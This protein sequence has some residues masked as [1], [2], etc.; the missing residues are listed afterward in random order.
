[1]KASRIVFYLNGIVIKPMTKGTTPRITRVTILVSSKSIVIQF[2]TYT[3]VATVTW[4]REKTLISPMNLAQNSN[5][6]TVLKSARPE[7][8]KTPPES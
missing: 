7:D 5:P 8:S 3:M 2:L 6:G 4:S 1:M